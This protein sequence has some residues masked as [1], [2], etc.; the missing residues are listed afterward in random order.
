[1]NSEEENLK[2]GRNADDTV[3]LTRLDGV[4]VDLRSDAHPG[5]PSPAPPGESAVSRLA[6]RFDRARELGEDLTPGQALR[7]AC[8]ELFSRSGE[9]DF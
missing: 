2:I 1:M 4:P 7:D 5:Y 3:R 8:P 9:K 6:R